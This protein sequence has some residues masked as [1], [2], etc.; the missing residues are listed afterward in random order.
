[1]ELDPSFPLEFLVAG[2]PVSLQSDN[3]R[4]RDQWKARVKAS[5]QTTL[6][7]GHFATTG[8]GSV[9]LYYFPS[10]A[11]EGDIDNIVKLILDAL[12]QH[13][14]V[15]DS[16]VERIVIQKF[17]PG[18]LFQFSSPSETLARALGQEKPLLYVRLSD[19]PFEELA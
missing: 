13:V 17:E 8:R 14:Y 11:M 6:P 15:D 9:T 4:S 5:S 18:S 16:Q 2:T 10:G 1:M 19:D 12:S 3:P 7:E